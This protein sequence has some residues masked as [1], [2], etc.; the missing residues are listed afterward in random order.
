MKRS[1]TLGKAV[2]IVAALAVTHFLA[3]WAGAAAKVRQQ[4]VNAHAHLSNVGAAI[5]LGEYF[6]GAGE[7]TKEHNLAGR[8]TR[9]IIYR[10]LISSTPGPNSKKRLEALEEN[11][12]DQFGT[13]SRERKES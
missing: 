2:A 9:G 7:G 5:T 1:I 4:G 8:A 13:A 6:T 11:L 3:Y 10:I 12:L